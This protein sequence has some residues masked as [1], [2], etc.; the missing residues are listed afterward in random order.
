MPKVSVIIPSFNHEK[1]VAM[2][3]QSVL[4]QSFQDFEIIIT[5]DASSDGTVNEIKK[6]NDPRIKLFI[7][8]R[9][10]GA[11]FAYTKCVEESRGEYISVLNSD[12]CYLPQKLEKQVKF[13]EEHP[14]IW[15]VFGNA[16]II[17]DKGLE[18]KDKEHFYYKIFAQPNRTRFEWLNYFFYNGN[19]L[20]HPSI[21]ARKECYE[22]IAPADPRY[23]Q[24]GDFHRWIRICFKHEIYVM[25]EK[26]VKFRVLNNEA[27]ASGSRPETNRRLCFEF[28]QILRNYLEIKTVEE[29]LRIFP[30]ALEYYDRFDE[31]IIPFYIAMLS[32]KRGKK[33]IHNK[34][35][36]NVLFELLGNNKAAEKIERLYNFRYS[37][38][39]KLTG[40]AENNNISQS[41]EE[42]SLCQRITIPIKQVLRLLKIFLLLNL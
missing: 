26:L 5:D 39:V 37:D 3:I 1:Y 27:N 2:A 19:C 36:L 28:P 40:K 33:S 25:P 34:F 18:F 8:E 6:F 15:A 17:N 9:N 32:L 35:A 23:A 22:K 38:F 11:A 31:D 16:E 42:N 12:D 20:C 30:E 10:T 24:L 41:K 7:F 29:F 14:D 13:L 4:Q 21:L